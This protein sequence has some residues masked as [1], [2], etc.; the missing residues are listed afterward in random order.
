M[1][2]P[3][4]PPL[5]E[6]HG[7]G[8]TLESPS[9]AR[10]R[11]G[12]RLR[13]WA[14]SLEVEHFSLPWMGRVG[15]GWTKRPTLRGPRNH[16]HPNPPPSRGRAFAASASDPNF[17]PMRLRGAHGP[18]FRRMALRAPAKAGAQPG[19]AS[20]RARGSDPMATVTFVTFACPFPHV[21]PA[22][23][24]VQAAPVP[25]RPDPA[26]PRLL[27]PLHWAAIPCP[28]EG[29][30]PL[31]PSR[32]SAACPPRLLRRRPCCGPAATEAAPA[33]LAASAPA[34]RNRQMSQFGQF[35]PLSGRFGCIGTSH[36]RNYRNLYC[37]PAA[38]CRPRLSETCQ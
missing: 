2:R 36:S 12:P 11:M 25:T 4:D 29:G 22:E 17:A 38:T 33:P 9:L 24:G 6:P 31:W 27:Q 18:S 34:R 10:P 19:T 16:P 8:A 30:G 14:L 21:T 37:G 23:A 13:A 32:R 35:R 5:S 26:Q 28:R 20:F 3:L 15:V 7:V 1:P